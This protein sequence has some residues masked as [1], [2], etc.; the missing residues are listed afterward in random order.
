MDADAMI[1]IAFT[2][3]AFLFALVA[4]AIFV[5]HAHK[6]TREA[7]GEGGTRGSEAIAPPRPPVTENE[8]TAADASELVGGRA[9]RALPGVRS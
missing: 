4:G 3:E 7:A 8:L 9:L 2:L 1:T 5:R 6:V